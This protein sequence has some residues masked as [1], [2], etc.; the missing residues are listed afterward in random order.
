MFIT[1]L[2]S[3][4]APSSAAMMTGALLRMLQVIEPNR[5]WDKLRQAY[6]HLKFAATPVRDKLSRMVPAADLLAL[7]IRLMD[8]CDKVRVTRVQRATRYPPS[9]A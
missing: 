5:A 1:E 2:K 3:R 4:V 7:G 9:R 8:T 6:N